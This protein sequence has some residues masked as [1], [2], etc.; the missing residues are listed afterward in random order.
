MLVRPEEERWYGKAG[1]N[2]TVWSCPSPKF[3]FSGSEKEEKFDHPTQKPMEVMR[4]P[5]L[6]HTLPCE[7]L[8]DGRRTVPHV[9][10]MAF[11]IDTDIP[12]GLNREC[13]GAELILRCADLDRRRIPDKA[14]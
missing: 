3:I 5:I 13:A 7:P 6:N 2:S 10:K 4:R 8:Y 12:S 11:E 1:E 9:D 14:E